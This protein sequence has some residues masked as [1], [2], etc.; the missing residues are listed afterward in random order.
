MLGVPFV[1]VD[2]RLARRGAAGV[3]RR[4]EQ[5]QQRKAFHAGQLGEGAFP[6]SFNAPPRRY[7]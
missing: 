5:D 1:V 7:K 2:P 6:A 3:C 4:S